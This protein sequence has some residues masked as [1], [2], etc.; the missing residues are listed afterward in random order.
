MSV[1][2]VTLN[3]WNSFFRAICIDVAFDAI[4]V[5]ELYPTILYGEYIQRINDDFS[6][7][8]KIN[9]VSKNYWFCLYSSLCKLDRNEVY[10]KLCYYKW[11]I[12]FLACDYVVTSLTTPYFE[13]FSF[14]IWDWTNH[15][16]ENEQTLTSFTVYLNYIK[17]RPWCV[18]LLCI[19]LFV[20]H[21][22][23]CY[24][25]GAY[26]D[27]NEMA[28]IPRANWCQRKRE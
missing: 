7:F 24:L 18:E 21:V 2:S 20:F 14:F 15:L 11:N 4:F 8:L 5:S 25:G 6:E 13:T 17:E 26:V 12:Y 16:F 1:E 10:C 27:K 22:G 9:K 3:V 23:K 19:T 28:I